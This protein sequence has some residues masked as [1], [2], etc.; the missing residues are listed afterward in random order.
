MNTPR[1]KSARIA[2][3]GPIISAALAI[4]LAVGLG[5][6][7]LFREQNKPFGFELEWMGEMIEHRSPELTAVALFFN[8]LGGGI[9]AIVVVP[10]LVIALLIAWRR[11][12]AASFFAIAL[13]INVG[14]VE[15]L[16]NTFDR[17]RPTEILVT[18]DFGS[19]P[20]GHSANAAVIAAVLAIVFRRAW[21]WA[22][23]SVYAVAM[24]LSRTYLGA[25]WVSDTIGGLLIGVGVA[26]IVAAPLALRLRTEREA[27][28]PPPW[29][30]A[31]KS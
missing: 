20:S 19:F 26:M 13:L 28:H 31:Q 10:V 12:W 9:V 3:Y 17:P 30:R 23:G 4:V 5:L 21:I 6:I 16:K 29:S 24:M 8:A 18:P 22:A 14:L 11:L 7:V 1:A 15:L 27:P 25:H 2:R